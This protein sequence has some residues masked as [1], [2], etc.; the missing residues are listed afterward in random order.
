MARS[1]SIGY[2]VSISTKSKRSSYVEGGL[3]KEQAM[4]MAMSLATSTNKI[5]IDKEYE[6]T[7][8]YGD[9]EYDSR[10]YGILKMVKRKSGKTFVLQTFDAYGWESWTYDVKPDGTLKN[11]R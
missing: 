10:P 2:S 11:R 1:K 9:V 5:E 7:D 8:R 4:M 6:K 3:S